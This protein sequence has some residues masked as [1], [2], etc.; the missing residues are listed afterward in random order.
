[1]AIY[2]KNTGLRVRSGDGTVRNNT[3]SIYKPWDPSSIIDRIKE[4]EQSRSSSLP[5]YSGSSRIGASAPQLPFE[6]PI[7][8]GKKDTTPT[9]VYEEATEKTVIT[10]SRLASII[11]GAAKSTASGYASALGTTQAVTGGVARKNY[12][13]TDIEQWQ[14]ELETYRYKAKNADDAEEQKYFLLEAGKTANKIEAAKQNLLETETA[15][16]SMQQTA[17]KLS[18][19]AQ[20]DIQEAKQGLGKVRSFLVDTGVAGAQMLGDVAVGALTGGS[21][22][23]SMF[24]RSAGSSAQEAREAGGTLG[25]QVAYGLGSGALSVATEKLLNVSTPF[26]KAFGEGVLDSAITKAAGKLGSTTLGKVAISAI[27]EGGEEFAEALMQP[28]LQMATYD[29]NAI[30]DEEWLSNALHD[31]AIGAAL[32]GIGGGVEAVASRNRT[33]AK[34]RNPAMPGAG[35]PT[36]EAAGT[37]KGNAESTVQGNSGGILEQEIERLFGKKNAAPEERTASY[38]KSYDPLEEDTIRKVSKKFTNLVVGRDTTISDFFN[39]WKNGRKSH[40]GEPL[41]KLYIGKV[42]DAAKRKLSDLLGYEV[43]STD[44]IITADNVK[45]IMDHHGNDA[46]EVQRG[47]L[48]ISTISMDTIADVVSHPD[49][50][51][52]GAT[53]DWE[54]ARQAVEFEKDIGGGTVVYVQFDNFKRGTIEPRTLYIRKGTSTSAV[55]TAEN[56]A[57]TYTPKATEPEAPVNNVSQDAAAV[58]DPL[59]AAI[60]QIKR[61]AQAKA[62]ADTDAGIPIDSPEGRQQFPYTNRVLDDSREGAGTARE[63]AIGTDGR[64]SIGS[65]AGGFS[66]FTAAQMEYGTMD[67]GENAVR[68]D[69][70]PV[71]TNGTDRVSR[72]V[73]TAKG[74]AVTPD[75]F[76]PLLEN[77]TMKGQFSYIPITNGETVQK[78]EARIMDAGWDGALR[79]WI[80]AVNRGDAGEVLVAEGALLYNN[81]VNSGN[82][83]LAMDIFA[84]YQG[85]VRTGARMTQAARILKTLTPESRLYMINR[86]IQ[87]MVDSL[88]LS[89]KI[90]LP[91][92][93]VQTYMAAKTDEDI[94]KAVEDIQQYVADQIPS[95]LLDKWTALRYVNMLGNFKT[96]GRNIIGNVGMRL[97]SEVQN[98]VAVLGQKATGGKYGKT[99][100]LTVSKD[101]MRAAKADFTNAEN[102]LVNEGK[103]TL[104]DQSGNAFMRG[105]KERQTVFRG[106]FAPLEAYR[107]AANWSMNNE[108]FGDVG[109]MKSAY[110]RFL[111][112][113]LEANGYT[114]Q[115]L[116]DAKWREINASGLDE[117]RAFAI[118][119]AQ[120]VTFRDSNWLSDWVST[121][122]RKKSTPKV[123]RTVSEGIMPFRKTPANVLYRAEEYSPAGFLNAAVLAAKKGLSAT[124]IAKKA[125]AVGDFARAGTEVSGNDI[126]ESLSKALTGTGIFALGAFLTSIGAMRGADDEDEDQAAFDDLTGHQAYSL[127]LPDG[128]SVTMDW[129][130][131]L[132]IPMFMGAQFYNLAKED[133]LEMKDLEAALMSMADP[134]VQMS[135]M[136]GVEE[137]LSDIKYSDGVGL[138]RI[139]G[140]AAM[141]YLTQ[142]LTNSLLGQTERAF[143]SES[144]MNYVDRESALPDWMQK[145]I[146]AAS[147]KFPGADYNQVPYI[148]AWGRQEE[149][150]DAAERIFN[151]FFNPAYVSQWDVDEVEKELQRVYDAVGGTVE[152]SI[153][154][155]RADKSFEYTVG[156][157]DDK[158]KVEKYLTAEEYT[159]YATEKG[160][161]SYKYVK[162]AINSKAYRSMSDEEKAKFLSKM[163][164]YANYKAKRSVAEDYTSDTYAQYEEA[165]KKGLSPAEYYDYDTDTNAMTADRDKDGDPIPGSKKQ[166]VIDYIEDLHYPAFIKDW[167]YLENYPMDDDAT[168]QERKRV[169]RQL[170]WN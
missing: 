55:N 170:P 40:Q 121:L 96:Q 37:G 60:L 19:S 162:E 118:K 78:A 45:H 80:A 103:Y 13:T 50:I 53:E 99:R 32:G 92:S 156:D 145:G 57:S 27:S 71:S 46:K 4:E 61:E 64:R 128:T 84:D 151:N 143:E 122:G 104:N 59:L 152:T 12:L 107:K 93:L 1:M 39:K 139:L 70:V 82:P 149:K 6:E 91:N 15:G 100:S 72:S 134:M 25:Q 85:L 74:A 73:V 75:E 7:Q 140:S 35:E 41:E 63:N 2:N 11:T 102:A 79:E 47:N 48:P 115:Q 108:W 43:Q 167:M 163:Y 166:K 158:E 142:G 113:Y 125:G 20:Q 131:P 10:P 18:A 76:V 114:A 138:L 77:Q 119:Q 133:G 17:K 21:A 144:T 160:Q 97:V 135:M 44:Y 127:E 88:G 22:L 101:M 105:V 8:I 38:L 124:T 90:T 14:K 16:Q 169:L 109:F 30:Y 157:G 129:L 83:Q 165:E 81:A 146:G 164:G 112:G 56:A 36:V 34:P 69:D 130:S 9:Q 62:E 168:E 95:T 137:T 153:F 5:T 33:A 87:K 117:A 147:R 68:P 110:A 120:E 106:V 3:A 161:N 31:A 52:L 155:Q 26:K 111:G 123:I 49:R 154:P 150:G 141:N 132:A 42:T 136:Q 66:P 65:A 58:K 94:N 159:K 148:D 28:I 126:M 24:V 89:Q 98:S 67:G 29:K 51:H 54:A 116:S 86:D 23:P